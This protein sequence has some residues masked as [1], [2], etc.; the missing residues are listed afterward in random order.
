MLQSGSKILYHYVHYGR[1]HYYW[2][3]RKR[4]LRYIPHNPPSRFLCLELY[5]LHHHAWQLHLHQLSLVSSP[6]IIGGCLLSQA[7]APLQL[8]AFIIALFSILA[9]IGKVLACCLY[10]EQKRLPIV[11]PLQ[12]LCS[13]LPLGTLLLLALVVSLQYLIRS[14]GYSCTIS[15]CPRAIYVL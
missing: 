12:S 1:D 4:E 15:V 13:E 10:Q 6:L 2:S 7:F 9:C 11:Q 5:A 8:G 14:Y 3:H